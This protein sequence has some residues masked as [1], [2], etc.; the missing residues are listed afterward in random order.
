MLGASIGRDV[1]IFRG[2]TILDPANL[3]IGDNCA[4]GW[5]CVLDARGGITIGR[6][7]N[8]SS[9]VQLITADHDP[10]ARDFRAR[11]APIAIESRSWL[12]TG[13]IVLKGVTVH[14]GAIAAAGA[15]VVGDVDAF[16]IVGG[17]PAR[18]I[19]KRTQD[20]DYEINFRPRF[21]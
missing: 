2:T 9:D 14:E 21:F 3:T 10:D 4:I 19:G 20:L 6:N 8:I 12:A 15:T 13:V 5:R 7:V 1:A 16:T 11:L 18:V 17:V